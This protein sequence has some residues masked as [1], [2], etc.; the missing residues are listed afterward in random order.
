MSINW[1]K[2]ECRRKD[3]LLRYEQDVKSEGKSPVEKCAR[4][5]EKIPTKTFS[6]G[7]TTSEGAAANPEELKMKQRSK[8]GRNRGGGTLR[9][10]KESLNRIQESGS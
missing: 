7:A 1:Y 3:R 10:S 6:A 5:R 9:W 8:A 2:T 4:S